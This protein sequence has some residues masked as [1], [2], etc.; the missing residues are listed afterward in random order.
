MFVIIDSPLP[1]QAS[2]DQINT[3]G[4]TQQQ[5]DDVAE[6]VAAGATENFD[7]HKEVERGECRESG[8]RGKAKSARGNEGTAAEDGDG[9][10]EGKGGAS[11]IEAGV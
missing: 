5:G 11:K 8:R 2:P 9:C 4:E 6:S 10:G 3:G 1:A 7:P